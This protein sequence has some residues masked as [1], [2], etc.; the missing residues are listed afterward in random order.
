M[1]EETD[2][3]NGRPSEAEQ[4]E[5][6]R[7]LRPYFEKSIS[8]YVTSGGAGINIKTV[9]KYFH[10][11]CEE[12]KSSEQPDFIERSK[13]AKEQAIL[14]CEDQLLRLYKVQEDIEKQVENSI[15]Q[16]GGIP[17]LERWVYKQRIE[18]SSAIVNLIILKTTLANT[19]TADITLAKKMQELLKEYAVA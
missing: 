15:T 10:K 4:L 13:I 6:E 18:V 16:S 17:R 14:A 11:W 3:K 8:P 7:K 2:N 5:I 9:R 1:T 19:P 12:I